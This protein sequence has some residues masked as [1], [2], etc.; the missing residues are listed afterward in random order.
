MP[1]R[2]E[3][4]KPPFSLV[5]EHGYNNAARIMAAN[6]HPIKRRRTHAFG[7]MPRKASR[8][9]A[10]C[11]R[12]AQWQMQTV[13]GWER[14]ARLGQRTLKPRAVIHA[15]ITLGDARRARKGVA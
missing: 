12:A 10:A 6:H 14:K 1:Q 4:M 9:L 2:Q 11:W 5:V 13:A 15:S 3:E 7:A 8:I